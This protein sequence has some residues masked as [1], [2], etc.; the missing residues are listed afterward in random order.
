MVSQSSASVYYWN[1]DSKHSL[2]IVSLVCFHSRHGRVLNFRKI[3]PIMWL[4][5]AARHFTWYLTHATGRLCW[6]CSISQQQP[7]KF[8]CWPFA[9]RPGDVITLPI[10]VNHKHVRKNVCTWTQNSDSLLQLSTFVVLN[11]AVMQITKR[12][13]KKL[14]DMIL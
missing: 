14:S 2:L 10:A 5:R 12:K 8:K 1:N 11:D 3:T 9:V 13:K 7:S 4:S 6:W